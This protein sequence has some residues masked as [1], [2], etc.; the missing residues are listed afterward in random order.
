MKLKE[1]KA[2]LNPKQSRHNF[3]V[4]KN[5]INKLLFGNYMSTIKNKGMEFVDYRPY[6]KEDDGNRIDWRASL[7]A[8]QL[9]IRQTIEEK[10]VNILFLVDVSDSMLFSS[11]DK[12][13]CEY[14]AELVAGLSFAIQHEGNA[15]GL[16]L[17]TNNLIVKLPPR[18]GTQQ[19]YS[20]I[21]ELGK[22]KNYGGSCDLTTSIKH[23]IPLLGIPALVIIISDFINLQKDW[24]KYLEVLALKF[25][26]IGIVIRDP[27]DREIP[28]DAGYFIIE[29]NN[30]KNKL[31]IDTKEYCQTYKKKVEESEK[32]LMSSFKKAK[33]DC[34]ILQTNEDY[35]NPLIKFLEKRSKLR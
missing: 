3:T 18:I 17:F 2:N 26:V 10:A 27:R 1:F 13:K 8:N 24:N 5:V 30:T 34:L 12:L 21:N 25:D 31:I 32:V 4:H 22:A 20:I 9:L 15:I 19:Y 16:C 29:D 33:S 23:T 28:K 7:R 14:A 11:H 35:F 6:T